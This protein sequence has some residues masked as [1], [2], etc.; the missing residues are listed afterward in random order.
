MSELGPFYPTPG[1]KLQKNQHAWN[2]IANIIFLESPAFV[3]WSYSNTST[4]IVVGKQPH[5]NFMCHVLHLCPYQSPLHS[6]LT[7]F[8][9]SCTLFLHAHSAAH[10]M[11]IQLHQ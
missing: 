1:G 7:L 2:H 3:G 10:L 5:G 8:S 11:L 6:M 9:C 4:D